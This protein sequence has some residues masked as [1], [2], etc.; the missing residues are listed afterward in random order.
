MSQSQ[1]RPILK[2]D[3]C[4]LIVETSTLHQ[5]FHVTSHVGGFYVNRSNAVTFDPRPAARPCAGRT[6]VA[7]FRQLDP[8]FADAMQLLI[9]QSGALPSLLLTQPT[10]PIHL[11]A[12]PTGIE[13]QPSPTRA[14]GTLQQV[15]DPPE[16]PGQARDWND[17]YQALRELPID[18][19]EG[20]LMR[21]QALYRLT[22]DFVQAAAAAAVAIVNG[23]AV[24]LD[25]SEERTR[26]IFLYNN[27]FVAFSNSAVQAQAGV[28]GEAAGHVISNKEHTA[29]AAIDALQPPGASTLLNAAVD[30]AGYRLIAQ[31]II[32]GA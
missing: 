8:K 2:G 32:P 11:W 13:V 6:L 21:E 20:R 29:V 1:P 9:K 28:G 27:I 16:L 30:Y 5:P 18:T 19:P 24:A 22:S 14:A 3:L 17:E 10:F 25:G 31:A 26:Q 12:L 4:Y 15:L 7:L 23:N